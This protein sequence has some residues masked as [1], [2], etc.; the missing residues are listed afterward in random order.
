MSTRGLLLGREDTDDSL[1]V[2]VATL[3]DW[4]PLSLQTLPA[5]IEAPEGA[6]GLEATAP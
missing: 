1:A 6:L 5:S 4:S 3:E 2:V